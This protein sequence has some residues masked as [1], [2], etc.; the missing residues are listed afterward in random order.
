M[1]EGMKTKKI[2]K[3]WVNVRGKIWINGWR[4]KK[5]KEG[6]K[7]NENERRKNMEKRMFGCMKEKIKR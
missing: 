5:R 1:N 4:K 7:K 6:K 3:N 2:E